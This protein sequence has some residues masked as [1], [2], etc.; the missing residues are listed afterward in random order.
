MSFTFINMGLAFLEGF[1]L[2]I[3]PCILPILPIVLSGSLT[4]S[5]ARPLGII[6]G[7]V[8]VFALFT[9]FSRKLV[10]LLGIDLNILREVSLFLLLGFGFMMLSGYLS[11]K[12]AQAT[13]R[14]ANIGSRISA[15]N[16]SE[17]FGSGLLLGSLIGLIWT[18]CAGPILA[19]VIVQ[20]VIQTTTWNSF[21]TVLSFGIGA[22]TPMLIIAFMGRRILGAVNVFK[23]NSVLLRKLL[24]LIVIITVTYMMVNDSM[25]LSF[26]GVKKNDTF[27]HTPA[28]PLIHA[29]HQAYPAPALEGI[30]AWI[31]SGPLTLDDLKGQVVLI[32]FWAYSCINCVRT[33]PFLNAWYAQYHNQ[34]FTIIGVHSP[35]FDFERDLANVQKAVVQNHIQYPVALDNRFAT[36]N[37]YHNSYWPAHYLIDKNGDVVYEKFGE[38]DY[39][40]TENNIRFLLGMSDQISAPAAAP[41]IYMMQTPET[42]LGYARADSFVSPQKVIN[43]TKSEYHYPA[44]IPNNSWA[45]EGEWVIMAE[46]I[47]AASPAGI[48]INFNAGKVFAVMGQH[49]G[50]AIPVEVRLNGTLQKT[51]QV[52]DDTLYPLLDLPT[53]T[54]GILELTTTPGLEIY[55]FTFGE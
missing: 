35:E 7:F 37:N 22:A 54:Q 53:P 39:E 8:T 15:L 4:G 5:K 10:E 44:N 28:A 31:N 32:D 18:P 43:N 24:G 36:W 52:T 48:K 12:F 26:S 41:T 38:G 16:Q 50:H 17:G 42:Y 11:E 51:I 30:S 27:I 55:T 47:A 23:S 25:S 6:V 14:L 45:L 3:S 9:L 1:A 34:G 2:I 46:K 21:L 13:G 20:S 40:E 33:L 49:T 29:V 19:A